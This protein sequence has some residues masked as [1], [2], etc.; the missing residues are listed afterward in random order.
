MAVAPERE[1][2]AAL[3]RKGLCRRV[4]GEYQHERGRRAS[5]AASGRQPFCGTATSSGSL[6]FP[7]LPP[8]PLLPFSFSRSFWSQRVFARSG[9][10]R[11]SLPRSS[12][13]HLF[14]VARVV[15]LPRP[16]SVR[17]VLT[18]SFDATL[19]VS[20]HLRILLRS[21]VRSQSRTTSEVARS[22]AFNDRSCVYTRPLFLSLFPFL[23]LRIGKQSAR[24]LLSSHST[25]LL[26]QASCPRSIS[27]VVCA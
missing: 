2:V 12:G 14:E 8:S 17:L 23:P 27:L 22:V 1:V 9:R 11:R 16:L 20:I 18:R 24:C 10:L 7:S 4:C 26:T 5:P 19:R 3:L 15:L 25:C 6:L 21:F 13:T